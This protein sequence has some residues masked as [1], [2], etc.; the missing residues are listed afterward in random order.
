MLIKGI[1]R[2]I[3]EERVKVATGSGGFDLKLWEKTCKVEAPRVFRNALK[4]ACRL[5]FK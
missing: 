3:S 2:R 1:K 5:H 4:L